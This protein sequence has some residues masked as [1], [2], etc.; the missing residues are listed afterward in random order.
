VELDKDG[1]EYV[2]TIW[3]QSLQNIELY[4]RKLKFALKCT[5]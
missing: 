3:C 5:V 1:W 4:N 2:D